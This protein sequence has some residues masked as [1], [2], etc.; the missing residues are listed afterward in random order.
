MCLILVIVGVSKMKVIVPDVYMDFLNQNNEK[1]FDDGVL[2]DYD[3]IL[4]MYKLHE[5]E[6]YADNLVPIGND[7][8]DYELVMKA[9]KGTL[10]FGIIDQG[11]IGS[12]EPKFWQDFI[13]WYK[14]G[15]E[16][17]FETEEPE[18]NPR[19][20]IFIKALPEDNRLKVLIQIKKVF[21]LDIPTGELL[22]LA[23]NL[24]CFI[25]DEYYKGQADT[26]IQK[27]KLEDWVGMF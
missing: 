1:I 12:M 26:I 21:A 4:E 8:G 18:D 9:E 23:N 24:P 16:F 2:Y 3:E 13:N 22:K 14:E 19:V 7:N 25:T 5:Y 10:L 6:K 27:N 20:K 11:A 17:E 15:P